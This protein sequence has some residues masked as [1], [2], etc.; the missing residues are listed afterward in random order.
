MED[1]LTGAADNDLLTKAVSKAGFPMSAAAFGRNFTVNGEENQH[2]A[3]FDIF[4][5]INGGTKVLTGMEFIDRRGRVDLLVQPPTVHKDVVKG[6]NL[7]S[8][9]P[10]L[11]SRREAT[12]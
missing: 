4:H 12:S 2:I 7:I 10:H 8:V 3:S 5:I 9:F 11:V 1:I 6:L